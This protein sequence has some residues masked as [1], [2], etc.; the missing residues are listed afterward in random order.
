MNLFDAMFYL[1]IMMEQEPK[2]VFNETV[3]HLNEYIETQKEIIKLQ[4]VKHTS[5]ATGNTVAVVL[6]ALFLTMT[7]FFV[8]LAAALLCAD[9][10]DSLAK[11]FALVG[12]INC[13]IGLILWFFRESLVV[14][15]IQ[16]IIIKHFTE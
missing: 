15:P 7:Y 8:N 6:F 10:L 2:Q 4:A 1:A 5:G 11:A 16:N 3:E 13:L 12:G 14:K 9:Y